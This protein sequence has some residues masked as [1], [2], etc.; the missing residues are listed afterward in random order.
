MSDTKEYECINCRIVVRIKGSTRPDK[1]I[2]GPC[3]KSS[4]GDH[5]W[6]SK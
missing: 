6:I 2:S 4:R 5:N 3:P 1:K